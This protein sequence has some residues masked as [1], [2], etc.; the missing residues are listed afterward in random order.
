M[1]NIKPEHVEDTGKSFIIKI[2]DSKTKTQRSFVVSEYF[3][4]TVK[5]YINLRPLTTNTPLPFFVNYNNGKCTRQCVGIHKLGGVPRDIAKYLGLPNSEAYTGH[6]FRRSSATIL[7]DAGG[8]LLDLKRH[9][10]WRS[11]TVAEGYVDNSMT[12]KTNNAAKITSAIT[13]SNS[14]ITNN[15]NNL[16]L[17]YAS[18][19]KSNDCSYVFNNCNVT[20][21]NY[22]TTNTSI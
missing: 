22:H 16:H 3:Y 15:D 1:R 18:S 7:V 17:S 12:N 14:V 13:N 9:G 10:G 21:N 11:S 5:K 6:C 8:D 19:S 20:I 2:P 4:P